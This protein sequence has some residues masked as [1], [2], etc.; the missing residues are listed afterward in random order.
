MDNWLPLLSL[1]GLLALSA[2]FSSSETALFSLSRIEKSR[3]Q[4]AR[5]KA[6]RWIAFHLDHPRKVLGTILLGNLFVNTLATSIATLLALKWFGPAGIAPTLAVFTLL[7]ILFGEIFPKILAVRE[8]ELIALIN[9]IPLAVFAWLMTPVLN[10]VRGVSDWFITRM[11]KEKSSSSE[12]I[13]GEELQAMVKVGEE[14][15]ILDHQER[16]MIQKIFEMG[17]RPVREIMTP[18]VRVYGLDVED[19]VEKHFELIRQHHHTRFPVCKGSMDNILGVLSVQDYVLSEARDLTGLIKQ[20]IFVPEAKR[21]DDLLAE[22]RSKKQ[23]F[24]VCVDEFGGTAGIVTLE[25]IL[26]EVFGEFYDEYAV[27]ENPVRPYG[28]HEYLIEAKMPLSALNEEFHLR[29][30][31]EEA[32]TLGGLIL[33]RLG[34]VPEKG[35]ELKLSGCEVRVHEVIRQR[36]IRSV[37]L[38]VNP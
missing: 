6:Y 15:G 24:A 28:Y 5:P 13:S 23:D 22:F 38:R 32:T 19:S 30:E 31:A 2:F 11:V 18:R 34:A 12:T 29:L 25:D 26:E 35:K 8:N 7:L 20:P 4:K 10:G 16:K 27:V 33:E 3:L 21:V 9:S 14:E 17:A 1:A 36:Y 37:I